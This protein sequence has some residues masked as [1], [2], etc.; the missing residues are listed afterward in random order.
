M[1]IND[2]EPEFNEEE[3]I[4]DSYGTYS[5]LDSLSRCGTAQACVGEDLMPDEAREEY[6]KEHPRMVSITQIYDM[7]CIGKKATDPSIGTPFAAMLCGFETTL[8][9]IPIGVCWNCCCG[10]CT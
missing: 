3:L 8:P 2:N 7:S 9:L 10:C 6:I 5:E 1:E 4:M